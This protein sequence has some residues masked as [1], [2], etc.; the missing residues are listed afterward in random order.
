[1]SLIITKAPNTFG[2]DNYDFEYGGDY[3]MISMSW[4]LLS[5]QYAE[6]RKN[7]IVI[8]QVTERIAFT[9]LLSMLGIR[10]VFEIL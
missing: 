1:M 5:P 8:I 9:E 2:G 6:V 3:Y 4:G 7:R 10:E